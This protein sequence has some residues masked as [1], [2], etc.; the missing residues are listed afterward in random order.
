[1]NGT[2]KII[3]QIQSEAKEKADGI[4]A[5]AEEKAAAIY[6]EYEANAKKSFEEKLAAGEK[7]AM[8]A[9]AGVKRLASMEA[10]KAVL[11]EKQAL[12]AKAFDD[13]AASIVSMPEDKYVPFLAGLAAKAS[14]TGDELIVFNEKDSA[15]A[16]KVLEQAN[17]LLKAMGK[18]AE[19]KAAGDKGSF[20]GGILVRRDSIDVNCTV[21]VI[22]DSCRECLSAEVAKVLFS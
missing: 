16:D 17:G 5:A 14:E 9:E 19:L 21:E 3:A 6:A 22:I 12:V 11:G 13:A 10:R 15:I 7:E 8:E 20:K 18:K 1:M 4:I 2:E